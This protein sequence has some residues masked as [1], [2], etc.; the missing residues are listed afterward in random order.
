MILHFQI[1][2]NTRIIFQS[3]LKMGRNKLD[4]YSYILG[5]MEIKIVEDKIV[6]KR[7][8]EHN[9]V[10][11]NIVLYNKGRSSNFEFHVY[12]S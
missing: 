2:K 5:E 9:S 8:Y 12:L 1:S 6:L 3:V 7:L 10:S 11:M 4:I